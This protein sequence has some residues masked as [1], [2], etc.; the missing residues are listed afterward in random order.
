MNQYI[1]KIFGTVSIEGKVFNWNETDGREV[2]Q[3]I[4]QYAG[5][6]FPGWKF[7]NCRE[8]TI[9]HVRSG[10]LSVYQGRNALNDFF[11]DLHNIFTGI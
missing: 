8:I 1:C 10:A 4:S 3:Q 7:F 5:R 9:V 2:Y 11:K 6:K